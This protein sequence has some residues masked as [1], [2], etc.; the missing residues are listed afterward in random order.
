VKRGKKKETRGTE[1]KI[2]RK[3]KEREKR[4]RKKMAKHR[5]GESVLN[6]QMHTCV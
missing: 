5:G 1:E 6:G 2:S 4:E 3:K